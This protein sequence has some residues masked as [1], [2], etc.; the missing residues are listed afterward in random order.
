M[1]DGDSILLPNNLHKSLNVQQKRLLEQWIS[2]G[3]AYDEH[4]A[5]YADLTVADDDWSQCSGWGLDQ[6]QFFNDH[7]LREIHL[8]PEAKIDLLSRVE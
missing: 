5:F 8:G 2:Q 4:W 6:T 1:A 7:G 3:A